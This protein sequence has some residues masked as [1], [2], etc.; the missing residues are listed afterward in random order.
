MQGSR[1]GWIRRLSAPR[2]TPSFFFLFFLTQS[3][4]T[5]SL[6]LSLFVPLNFSPLSPFLP[7]E[8]S[9]FPR[10]NTTM[11]LFATRV[12][13]SLMRHLSHHHHRR[14]LLLALALVAVA[15]L[16]L[17]HRVGSIPAAASS[18]SAHVAAVAVAVKRSED[19]D[20]HISHR[21]H[22]HHYPEQ[23]P[24][25][26]EFPDSTEGAMGTERVKI[27]EDEKFLTY[28]PHSGFNNQRIELGEFEA[29]DR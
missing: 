9:R 28:L 10:L 25:K 15:C 29:N 26:A 22:P 19:D 6:F 27:N 21:N 8:N 13:L 24:M 11:S 14:T 17:T 2:A 18:F 5:Q 4:H 1:A 20:Q 3:N 7:Q 23:T 12:K 16:A